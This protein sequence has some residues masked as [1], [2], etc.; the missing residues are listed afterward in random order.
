MFVS[1]P[2]SVLQPLQHRGEVLY[3]PCCVLEGGKS[4]SR[5]L[6]TLVARRE[7]GQSAGVFKQSGVTDVNVL[8]CQGAGLRGGVEMYKWDQLVD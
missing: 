4:P 8:V 6:M 1:P 5:S 3:L 7:V 2:P